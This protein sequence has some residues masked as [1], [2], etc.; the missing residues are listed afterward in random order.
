MNV[1]LSSLLF[2]TNIQGELKY[3]EQC[4]VPDIETYNDGQFNWNTYNLHNY[5]T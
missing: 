5:A 1:E 3:T 2:V 4:L